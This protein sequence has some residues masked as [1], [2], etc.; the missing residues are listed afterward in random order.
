MRADEKCIYH[1]ASFILMSWFASILNFVPYFVIKN[2]SL[3]RKSFTLFLSASIFFNILF[4]VYWIWKKEVKVER[5]NTSRWYLVDWEWTLVYIFFRSYFFLNWFG[6]R[7]YGILVIFYWERIF[8]L[9]WPCSTF[10]LIILYFWLASINGSQAS[11]LILFLWLF[12]LPSTSLNEGVSTS[13]EWADDG[14]SS[15]ISLRF[16]CRLSSHNLKYYFR[17]MPLYWSFGESLVFLL[18][19]L[20]EFSRVVLWGG[21]GDESR[22]W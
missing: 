7:I 4:L 1:Y 2:A 14:D 20:V 5:F 16:S 3:N 12:F 10:C 18:V 22:I 21:S 8:W 15:S 9:L 19:S 11:V 6:S 17:V 13:E